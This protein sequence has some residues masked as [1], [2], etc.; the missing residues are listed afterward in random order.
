VD[1]PRLIV[2]VINSLRVGLEHLN[3]D[4]V[5]Q[6]RVRLRLGLGVGVVHRAPHGFVG[7]TIIEVC[8]LRDADIVREALAGSRS[9]LVAAFADILYRD[10]LAHGY[11]E[12]VIR[13]L[14]A[15]R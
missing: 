9:V 12:L 10:V 2:T 15:L 1:E 13:P 14:P 4:L 7:P 3:E 11:H 5:E 6:A 8:R